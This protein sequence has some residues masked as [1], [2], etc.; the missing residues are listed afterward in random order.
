MVNNRQAFNAAFEEWAE[1]ED[2]GWEDWF[3]P[4][5]PPTDLPEY[6]WDVV[7]RM[8]EAGETYWSHP[9]WIRE[10][11]ETL[12]ILARDGDLIRVRLTAEW[13]YSTL[14]ENPLDP[15]ANLRLAL[16]ATGHFCEVYE[17]ECCGLTAGIQYY[18]KHLQLNA[19][20]RR[21]EWEENLTFEHP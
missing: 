3:D 9:G 10:L 2:G 21:L 18:L 20:R 15:D 7:L 13:L 4:E 19:A 8:I 1:I 16:L 17:G 11:W 14:P 6:T 12:S 5:T